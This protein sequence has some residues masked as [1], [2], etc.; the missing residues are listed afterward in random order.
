VN[1][2][3][4]VEFEASYLTE[5][6]KSIDTL[7]TDEG[8]EACSIV[9]GVQYPE[10]TFIVFFGEDIGEVSGNVNMDVFYQVTLT[11]AS[12]GNIVDPAS[13]Q[14]LFIFMCN[15]EDACDRKFWHDHI[16]W[17]IREESTGL[18]AAFRSILTTE[19]K[20]KGNIDIFTRNRKVS[21]CVKYSKM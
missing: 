15:N 13:G 16:D 9:F 21:G 20:E 18:E 4:P 17:F 6:K 8:Y 19:N 12:N 11:M 7:D 14:K 2:T 10:N 5:I 3:N 1:D